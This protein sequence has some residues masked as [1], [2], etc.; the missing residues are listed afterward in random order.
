MR[1]FSRRAAL[2]SLALACC[3]SAVPALSQDARTETLEIS[4]GFTRASPKMAQVG[5]GF[6]TIR[7]LGEADRLVGF[8]SPACTRPELHTHIH[9]NGVM[10]M[11]QVDAIDIPA[12]GK[13]ALQPGGL[14]LMMIGLTAPLSEGDTVPLTLIFEQAG[15][16]QISL[17]VKGPG[18]MN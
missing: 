11:R 4:G 17:P 15:E 12:G 13:V 9:D 10:R 1:N 7:S 18:A 5:A 6:L 8:T 3:M 2:V 14:H 16:V